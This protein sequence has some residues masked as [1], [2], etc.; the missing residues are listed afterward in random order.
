MKQNARVKEYL[1]MKVYDKD[2]NI[3]QQRYTPMGR[4]EELRSYVAKLFGR[5]E[6]YADDIVVDAG[7]AD[8]ASMIKDRYNYMSI[9]V[10]VLRTTR[11]MTQLQSEIGSR[12]L[13]TKG[14]ETT[15]YP[16]DTITFMATFLIDTPV[17]L[18]EAGIHKES[19]I[20]NDIMLCRETYLGTAVAA[21]KQVAFLWKV[22][23]MR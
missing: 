12:S 19:S 7:L 17:T 5:G 13:C 4:I 3:E 15:Y 1:V 8:I 10:G 16:G 22:V 2:G 14:I 6:C 23:V 9:G 21:G 20:T 18:R 11:L